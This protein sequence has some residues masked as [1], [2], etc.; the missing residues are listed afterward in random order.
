MI[1]AA[2]AFLLGVGLVVAGAELFAAH[3][4]R[5]AARLGAS[6]FALGILLAGAEPEELATVVFASARDAPG[7]AFGDVVGANI[8][9]SLVAV[10]VAAV[11]TRVRFDRRLYVY[12]LAGVPLGALAVALAW[13]GHAGRTEGALLVALYAAYVAAVWWFDRGVPALGEAGELAEARADVQQGRV[14]HELFLAI[15][16]VALLAAGSVLI[17]ETVRELA[18]IEATEVRLGV[19]LVG[20]ATAFELVVLAWS[21][22]RRRTIETALAGVVG[23]FAYNAT[24]TLGTGA[25]VRPL[26]LDEVSVLRGPLALMPLAFLLPIA[27]ALLARGIGRRGGLALIALDGLFVVYVFS[28]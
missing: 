25:L 28:T 11:V 27:L 18:D 6:T 2:I 1:L 21:A 8:A 24:M 10:G 14:G 19:T 26:Q 5:A 9:L 23:S 4:S 12:S 22:A 17:V 3:L 20:F 16:G 7:I 15:V 13:D